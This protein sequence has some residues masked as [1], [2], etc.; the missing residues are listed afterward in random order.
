[1]RWQLETF[2]RSD[3]YND[4][5]FPFEQFGGANVGLVSLMTV[6]HPVATEADAEN[7]VARLGQI[8]AEARRGHRRSAAH[9][10]A[11]ASFR[12][13]SSSAPRSR[14]CSSS[15][16]RRP[17]RIRW[18]RRSRAGMAAAPAIPEARR[19]ALAAE[20]EKVVASQIYPAWQRAIAVVQPL[21][22]KA[23]D[24]AGPVAVQGRRGRV[25]RNAAPLHDDQP[26]RRPDPPDRLER[27]GAHREG[28]GRDPAQARAHAGLGQGSRRAAEEGSELSADRGRTARGSWPTSTRSCATPR[29]APR[30]S[31]IAVRRRRSSRGPSSGSRKPTPPRTTPPRRATDRGRDLPDPAA[32]GAH[33]EVQPA[34]ARL[35]RDRPGPPLPG[36]AR[37]REHRSAAVPPDSRLRSD[38]GVQRRLGPLRRA[39]GGGDRVGTTATPRGCSASSI[40][41]CSAPAGW[42]ST[43]ASTPSAGRG[44]R[45]S[46]TAS[47]RA[48][49]SATSST[50]ARPART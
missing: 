1:M 48:K 9:R 22:A 31:S 39:A 28:D 12:R 49:S 2:V 32:A 40:P 4:Y 44:S 14:R 3:R 7:Y 18:S 21:E 25:C 5:F 43:P 16:R 24:D 27:G 50:R 37:A 23:T 36:R 46:T 30:R 19:P 38:L 11:A 47:K 17:R 34:L 35:P 8:R 41:R 13:D 45:R 10:R 33:D 20:A 42:S 6:S 15:S 26:D 29:S